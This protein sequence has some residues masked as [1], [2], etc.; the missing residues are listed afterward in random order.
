MRS[1]V[2]LPFVAVLSQTLGYNFF[3]SGP[4]EVV[5]DN[6]KHL[7]CI[8]KFVANP[9]TDRG[10]PDVVTFKFTPS[11]LIDPESRRPKTYS[12]A[13]N[14][15]KRLEDEPLCHRMAAR[16]LIN[17]CRGLEDIDEHN[18]Q[19]KSSLLQRTHMES[20]AC[21][22]TVCD[23][24][25]ARSSIPEQCSQYTSSSLF[26]AARDVNSKLEVSPSQVQDCLAGLNKDPNLW[27]TFLD[28]RKTAL[29][30][31]SAAR[32]DIDKGLIEPTISQ[33]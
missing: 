6:G 11:E 31:C 32:A 19:A 28:N 2:L 29:L 18:Y 33:Q 4:S 21:S 17:N 14:E 20:F 16:L 5:T 1:S 15:L 24:E 23:M 22:L 7:N 3:S 13:I 27:S 8:D 30:F 12:K 9:L 25:R 26:R 10:R